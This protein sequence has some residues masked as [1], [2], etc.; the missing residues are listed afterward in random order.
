MTLFTTD[1]YFH[2]GFFIQSS[3]IELQCCSLQLNKYNT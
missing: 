1:K 3:A 2:M